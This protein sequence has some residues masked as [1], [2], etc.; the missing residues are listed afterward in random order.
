MVFVK[1]AKTALNALNV[2]K[3]NCRHILG[4]RSLH[5]LPGIRKYIKSSSTGQTNTAILKCI[6]WI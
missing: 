6:N 2:L 3:A 4:V 5:V 1:L